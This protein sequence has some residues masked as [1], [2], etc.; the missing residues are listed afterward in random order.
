MKVHFGSASTGADLTN[1]YG[2]TIGN[3]FLDAIDLRSPF[4]ELMAQCRATVAG[5][6][7]TY[8]RQTA[9]GKGDSAH[10]GR[11]ARLLLPLWGNGRVEMLLGAVVPDKAVKESSG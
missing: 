3:K 2:E 7:P 5:G 9:V 11:Y 10:P 6:A 4:D 1:W 8:Y